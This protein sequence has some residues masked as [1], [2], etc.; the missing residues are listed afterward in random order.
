MSSLKLRTG[1]VRQSSRQAERE[2]GERERL[3]DLELAS[4]DDSS[5]SVALD[6]FSDDS[7]SEVKA[8]VA[9][10]IFAIIRRLAGS[11]VN[12]YHIGRKES[13]FRL[14]FVANDKMEVPGTRNESY[15]MLCVKRK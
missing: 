11:F 13:G 9:P 5:S 2:R 7:S 15:S 8:Y 1:D 12:S 14:F 6:D 3:L 4:P 10:F